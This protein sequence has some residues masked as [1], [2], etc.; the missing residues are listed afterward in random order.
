MKINRKP[1]GQIGGKE[2]EVIELYNGEVTVE[3]LNYGCVIKS[4]GIPNRTGELINVVAGFDTVEGYL[5]DQPFIGCIIGRYANRIANG[6]FELNGEVYQL[7]VNQAPNTL[8]SGN[9]GLDKKVWQIDELIQEPERVG[10]KLTYLSEDGDGGFPGNLTLS[11]TYIFKGNNA[12]EI[13]YTA[14]SDKDTIINLTNHSYFNLNGFRSDTILDHE[15]WINASLYT[16]KDNNAIPTGEIKSV[17]G[18][19]LDFSNKKRIGEDISKVTDDAGYD[20]NFVLMSNG[21]LKHAATLE[22]ELSGIVMETYTTEPGVQV[23]TSNWMDGSLIGSQKVPYGKYCSV[24]L[25]TQHFPDSPHHDHFPSTVLKA[26]QTF[27]SKTVYEFR[28]M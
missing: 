18:T 22:C 26:G 2:V 21:E 15:L 1:F 8:H 24:A 13:K 17:F 25:E 27:E 4:I 11:C 10:V 14:V 16:P 20:H 6:S 28:F 12:L 19:P 7:E 23:Y 3:I 5:Q 9:N